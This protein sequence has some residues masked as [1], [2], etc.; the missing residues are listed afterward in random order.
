MIKRIHACSGPWPLFNADA[1]RRLE[2]AALAASA[3]HALMS[4]AGCSVA[5]LALAVSP[6]GESIWIAAGP[7]NNGGDGLVAARHL[8]QAGK[9]VTV[10]LLG[11]PEG[12]PADAQQALQEAQ[13]AGVAVQLGLPSEVNSALAIDA[14][15][16]LGANR[17]PQGDVAAAIQLLNRDGAPP[18]LAVDL[19]SGLSADTGT[20]FGEQAVRAMHSLA[21]L[22]LK[23]GLFTAQG[24]DHAGTVWFDALGIDSSAAQADAQLLGPPDWPRRAHAQHKGSFGDVLVIGGAPGMTGAAA[25]ASTAALTAGA[26]RVHLAALAGMDSP[27]AGFLSSRPELMPRDLSQVLVPSFLRSATV[28]C[29]CGGGEAVRAALP[30]ALAD[31]ARLVLDA[32]ALNAVGKDAEFARL[33]RLRADHGLPT[34]LTPHPLEAARLLQ[35]TTADVQADRIRSAQRLSQDLQA[36]VVL[37]GSGTVIAFAGSTPAINPTGNA[38]LGTAGSG[39]VLAGWIGGLWAQ[40]AGTDGRNA[41]QAATWLHGLAAEAGDLRLPLRAADLIEQMAVTLTR[42]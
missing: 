38:R 11:Q 19:P 13:Q 39:D 1:S 17:A 33:L 16:G 32:D 14:L 42:L 30:A 25:L 20:P 35:S 28:V 36:G 24:R 12:M 2:Q 6:H 37:K 4:A 7:G 18:V 9:K 27:D 29:G 31:A 34:V 8:M 22:N 5:R 10:S 21:L 15:L 41:A 40:Q 26:G 23:P 3:P